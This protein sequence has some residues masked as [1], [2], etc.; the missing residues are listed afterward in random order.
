MKR[1]NKIGIIFLTTFLLVLTIPIPVAAQER[2]FNEGDILTFGYQ[3]TYKR[4]VDVGGGKENGEYEL[5]Q[6]NMNIEIEDIDTGNNE[7]EYTYWD[8]MGE[9]DRTTISYD[10]DM[11]EFIM[12]FKPS[13]I[14]DDGDVVVNYI[15]GPMDTM[16]GGYF[17]DPEWD[18][19]NDN[20][21]DNIDNWKT[22]VGGKTIDMDDFASEAT[23]FTLMGK[24]DL[25]EG[26]N[27]FTDTTHKW[28]GKIVFEGNVY[29]WDGDRYREYDHYELEWEAEYTAGGTLAKAK[30]TKKY[31]TTRWSVEYTKQLQNKAVSLGALGGG[32]LPGVTHAFE[33]PIMILAVASSTVALRFIGS[34]RR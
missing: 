18:T 10:S 22:T 30:Q 4:I 25:D 24:S 34:R 1:V 23:T 17:I 31:S 8:Q 16:A 7:I 33:F 11:T 3:E 12:L 6:A 19:I 14:D 9:D 5:V 29:Y 13:Y 20:L 32:L 27:A 15:S 28:S 21:A 2:D 26:L